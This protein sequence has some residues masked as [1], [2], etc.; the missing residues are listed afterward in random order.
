MR[1]ASCARREAV[2]QGVRNRSLGRAQP[3][4]SAALR[5]RGRA[6][7]S[8]LL[9]EPSALPA[10]PRRPLRAPRPP[11]HRDA[12]PT[13]M[14][15]SSRSRNRR[16]IKRRDPRR[17]HQ[18]PVPQGQEGPASS[19]SS[20]MPRTPHR[21]QAAARGDR[22]LRAPLLRLGRA[23][24]PRCSASSPGSVTPFGARQRP[25]AAG[26]TLVL[27]E[28]LMRARAGQFP[29]ARE[30]RDDGARRGP[31]SCRSSPRPGTSRRSCACP[32][33]RREN[34]GKAGADPHLRPRLPFPGTAVHE[35][36][37][38]HARP[39]IAAA[40]RR[41]LVK[42][43]TTADFR[44]DVIEESTK[45]PVLVDFWAPWCGPCKQL[46]PVLEKAVKAAGGKVKLVK[47]NI[48]EHPQI[49]GQLGIQSIPAVIAFTNG[50]PVDGFMG[51]LPESQVK[52]LHRAPRRP[53]RPERRPRTCSPQAE[54]LAARGRRRRRR[55][56]LRRRAGSRSRRTSPP[57]RRWPAAS[58][59]RRA[60][61]RASASSPWRR[62][63]QGE[64]PGDRRRPRRDRARR[65]GGVA[66]RHRR[67]RAPARGRTRTT[68]RRA[69]TS[70]W[71]STPR[72]DREEAIDAAARHRRGATAPGTTRRRASSS[73]S[74]SRPGARW[75]T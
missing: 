58:R 72:G 66:R 42:D 51:A 71:R 59:P 54:A 28:A 14:R 74:S 69:S 18:E 9:P 13:S 32:S 10:T 45:Q 65:A 49:A 61:G 41:G 7:R 22:R 62:S 60:R 11:R 33:R 4:A 70:R 48:D 67:A 15:R 29:S 27:D 50:Q 46:T 39:T 1:G 25:R 36:Q 20:P 16:R 8:R 31:I 38:P 2:L 12:R 17:P 23:A 57:S 26:S 47:M 52:A 63:A 56:A 19:S 40:S 55:R 43:T 24:A 44:Q 37:T 5:R 64:R 73:S 68:I 53:G 6:A 75:T 21:P 3:G 35:R 34:C 30:H